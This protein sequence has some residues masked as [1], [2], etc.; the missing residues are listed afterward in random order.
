MLNENRRIP[1]I[2]T[3]RLKIVRGDGAGG[4]H[5]M[6]THY[7]SRGDKGRRANPRTRLNADGFHDEIEHRRVI[8]VIAGAEE[9]AWRNAN[10]FSNRD[11]LEVQQPAFLAQPDII[12]KHQFPWESDGDPLLDDHAAPYLSPKNPEHGAFQS[13]PFERT[14]PEQE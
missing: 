10:V 11:L 5:G 1:L 3:K 13:R 2:N 7:D 4:Q 12:S 14:K 6:I 8:V 9:R